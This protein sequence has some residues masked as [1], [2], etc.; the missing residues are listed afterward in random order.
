[1]RHLILFLV[2]CAVLP[3]YTT[4]HRFPMS[5][6][7]S[8]RY[9]SPYSG[10]PKRGECRP[11]G[12]EMNAM[13]SVYYRGVNLPGQS[14]IMQSII[15]IS[16]GIIDGIPC[17]SVLDII[18]ASFGF[19]AMLTETLKILCAIKQSISCHDV[20]ALMQNLIGYG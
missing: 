18:Q 7:N 19:P 11:V 9:V 3:C 10:H 5:F 1:M 16:C 12:A 8:C 6:P 13:S 2:I 20:Y 17:L 15:N 14:R 4:G